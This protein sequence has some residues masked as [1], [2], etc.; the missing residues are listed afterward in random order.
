[1]S[2]V[3]ALLLAAGSSSRMKG[4]DKLMEEVRGQPLI[5]DRITCLKEAGLAEIIVVLRDDRPARRAAIN[6]HNDLTLLDARAPDD[7]MGSSI[8]EGAKA[9]RTDCTAALIL[10]ADMPGLTA[11]DIQTFLTAHGRI[12]EA[13]LR[14]ATPD[15]QPGHPVLFPQKHVIELKDLS[16][17]TGARSVLKRHQ[18]E[19]QLIE[20]PGDNA[21][22]DLDTPEAWAAWRGRH[23]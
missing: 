13:I 2:S 6:Q 10:P 1:M 3:A 22:L 17:D 16:G 18:E 7:G 9:I 11:S 4:R 12:P 19:V 8:A 21:I 23:V 14:G 20:I 5:A 15:G